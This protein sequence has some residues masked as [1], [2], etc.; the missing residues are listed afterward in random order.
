MKINTQDSYS[1]ANLCSR[2]GL[3][4]FQRERQLNFASQ[5]ANLHGFRGHSGGYGL[6]ELRM[7]FTDD[8][9]VPAGGELGLSLLGAGTSKGGV[10]VRVNACSPWLTY[11][12]HRRPT[13]T[14]GWGR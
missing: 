5:T 12:V 7:W 9:G 11:T 2:H 13:K 6:R 8:P 14:H 1:N 4:L 10:S 3:V